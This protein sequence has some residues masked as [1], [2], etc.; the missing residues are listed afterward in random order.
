VQPN[1]VTKAPAP[2]RKRRNRRKAGPLG[3]RIPDRAALARGLR[4]GLRAALPYLAVAGGVAAVGAGG[5]LGYRWLLTSD[6]F[7]LEAIEISGN[8][9][10]GEA[11]ILARLPAAEGD[12]IFRIDLG[13]ATGEVARD[14]WIARA[15]VSRRLPDR[16]VVEVTEHRPAA[17]VE[18]DGL[19]LADAEGN[20]FKRADLL[21]GDAEGEGQMLPIVTGIARDE[22]LAD[23]A[24]TAA[25]VREA[26]AALAVYR[27]GAG[28]PAVGEVRLDPRRGVLLVT[29]EHAITLRLGRGEPEVLAT[30]LEVFDA[31]W[32]TLEPEER[33]SARVIYADNVTRPDRITVAFAEQVDN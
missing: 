19:Y 29:T 27:A 24:A 33:T 2:L 7:A 11:R 23:P 8:Q 25:R 20:V 3:S 22:H 17:L 10:A 31:A 21:A 14:P 12:N 1:R 15:E 5:W 4:R 28:R 30:R 18:L 32:D 13:A 26:L 16:L 6:R 9:R